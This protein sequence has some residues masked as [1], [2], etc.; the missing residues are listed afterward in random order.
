MAACVSHGGKHYRALKFIRTK[1]VNDKFDIELIPCAHL[2]KKQQT[3]IVERDSSP[4][5]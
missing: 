3:R 5:N 4:K 2:N 1:E